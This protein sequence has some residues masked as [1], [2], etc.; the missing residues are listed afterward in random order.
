MKARSLRL[1]VAQLFIPKRGIFFRQG[2]LDVCF[3]H[4]HRWRKLQKEKKKKRSIAFFFNGV[5][6]TRGLSKPVLHCICEVV[7]ENVLEVNV[8]LHFTFNCDWSEKQSILSKRAPC[9][10]SVDFKCDNTA[11]TRSNLSFRMAGSECILVECILVLFF[12][13]LRRQDYNLGFWSNFSQHATC[14][15]EVPLKF[16]RT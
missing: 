2:K 10:C 3:A 14:S 8:H 15:I 6:V 5:I 13:C 16:V 9:P 12:R 1:A 11:I 4:F 7:Q